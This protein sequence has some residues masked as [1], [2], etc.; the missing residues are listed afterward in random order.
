ME[1]LP[2]DF[3]EFLKLLND[4]DVDYMLV[5]GYAVSIYGYPRYTG[6]IDFWIDNSHENAER[7]VAALKAF[8]F[9]VPGLTAR[10]FVSP[11][12]ITR[13]GGNH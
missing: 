13:R 5:G 2:Q 12:G 10:L 4:Y 6:D 8:G 3:K 9:D 1:K 7:V 11:Q